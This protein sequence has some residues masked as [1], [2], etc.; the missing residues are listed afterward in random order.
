[1]PALDR[2]RSP[3]RPRARRA[4]IAL[5]QRRRRRAGDGASSMIFW[6]R[7][8]IEHSRSNRCTR[9]P[10]R[11]PRIWTSTWRAGVRQRSR[12]T[13]PSPNAAA[14]SRRALSTASARSAGVSTIR[15]PRAAAAGRRLDQHRVAD[16][17]RPPRRVGAVVELDG[18]E[19]R[20]R[21]RC[22]SAAWPRACRPSRAIASGDG[23]TQVRPGVDHGLRRTRRSPTGSRSPGG[24]RRRRLRSA[25]VDDLADVEVGLRRRAAAE[26][27]RLVGLAHEGRVGVGVGVDRDGRDAHRARGAED[28]ARDLA[29]VGDQQPTDRPA[30]HIRKS[31]TPL[32]PA[33]ALLWHADSA[34]PSTVRVSRGSMMPSS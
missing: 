1:M 3:A 8:W 7:R 19:Q 18:L 27:D 32:V 24:P 14:A 17:S 9:L 11:S 21:R 12:N 22:A 23:P 34:M 29:A 33:T 26:R 28:A 5:A 16:R 13:V 10:C 20:A 25:G 30:A 15:M 2:S 31:R 4:P 6:W